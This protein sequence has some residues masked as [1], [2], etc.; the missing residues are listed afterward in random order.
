MARLVLAHI[1]RGH[2]GHMLVIDGDGAPREGGGDPFVQLLRRSAARSATEDTAVAR[3]QRWGKLWENHGKTMGFHIE[4]EKTEG[5]PKVGM[6][7]RDIPMYGNL[8]MKKDG[9]KH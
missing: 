9:N 5:F 6:V 3:W 4:I 8:H 2:W 7:F 1:L